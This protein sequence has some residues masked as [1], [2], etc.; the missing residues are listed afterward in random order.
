[1]DQMVALWK[2]LHPRAKTGGRTQMNAIEARAAILSMR[3]N[4]D[5]WRY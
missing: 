3:V 2:R 4:L 1:M 5:W